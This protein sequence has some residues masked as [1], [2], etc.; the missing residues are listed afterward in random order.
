MSGR[1]VILFFIFFASLFFSLRCQQEKVCI[2]NTIC[3]MDEHYL[4]NEG[5]AKDAG[6]KREYQQVSEIQEE[7][8]D[9]SC[10][11]WFLV[12]EFQSPSDTQQTSNTSKYVAISSNS[13]FLA[14]GGADCNEKFPSLWNSG[15]L[16]IWEISSGNL[17]HTEF[18]ETMSAQCVRVS[19][20]SF[21]QN[22][23]YLLA[24]LF[25]KWPH[26]SKTGI[27]AIDLQNG[28]AHNSF[29]RENEDGMEFTEFHSSVVNLQGTHI[30]FYYELTNREIREGILN[31]EKDI[32]YIRILEGHMLQILKNPKI[33]GILWKGPSPVFHPKHLILVIVV[34]QMIRLWDILTGKEILA[35]QKVEGLDIE[36]ST[37]LTFSHDGRQLAAVI[38]GQS[39]SMIVLWNT[40]T[41]KKI[42]QEIQLNGKVL[43]LMF[44]VNNQLLYLGMTDGTIRQRSIVGNSDTI[45]LRSS[46]TNV[47]NISF[48]NGLSE[49]VFRDSLSGKIQVWKKCGN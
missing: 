26:H 22:A 1:L 20:L 33:G 30:A 19:S 5:G 42:N 21:F 15:S 14:Y 6:L 24:S 34:N 27:Y 9:S 3:R 36:K 2:P 13:K 31:G 47:S 17:I 11:G 23:K 45:L 29:F 10:E 12:R 8:D 28:K 16:R 39:T 41:G 18:P 32:A 25:W 38:P 43:T 49:I 40:E 37:K 44:S 35:L 7:G 4:R 46:A 48:G